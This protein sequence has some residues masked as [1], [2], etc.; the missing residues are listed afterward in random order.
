MKNFKAEEITI[1]AD[2]NKLVVR[3]QKS[4]A[5]GDAAMSESV[6][7]SIPLPP[8]VDRNHIQATITTVGWIRHRLSLAYPLCRTTCW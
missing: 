5:C 1:K 8:S 6:G 4:V 3:A 7:R 2:K